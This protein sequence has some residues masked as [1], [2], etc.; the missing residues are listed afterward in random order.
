MQSKLYDATQTKLQAIY[1]LNTPK[2]KSSLEFLTACRY[3]KFSYK[4]SWIL[5][6]NLHFGRFAET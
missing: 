4:K 2:N 1:M 6:A 5:I 3:I